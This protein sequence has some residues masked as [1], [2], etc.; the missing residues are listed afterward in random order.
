MSENLNPLDKAAIEAE[1][2]RYKAEDVSETI[3]LRDRILATWE[4]TSPRM[5]ANLQAMGLTHKLAFVVQERMWRRKAELMSE[6]Y[7]VTDARET[8][9]REELMLEPETPEQQDSSLP[10]ELQDAPQNL[11]DRWADENQQMQDLAD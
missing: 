8:A 10:A 7:P 5:W 9:E 1:Y 2:R 3:P 6:G 11:K 4:Q